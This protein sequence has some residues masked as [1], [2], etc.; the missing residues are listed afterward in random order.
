MEKSPTRRIFRTLQKLNKIEFKDF[1]KFVCSPY[2]NSNKNLI[3]YYNFLERY[4]PKFKEVKTTHERIYKALFPGKKFNYGILRNLN[5]EMVTVFKEFLAYNNYRKKNIQLNCNLLEEL[6]KRKLESLFN[7]EFK[8]TFEK[9]DSMQTRDED[10]YLNKFLLES[11]LN[12]YF[13]EKL[14]IGK[15][16][17]FYKGKTNEINDLTNYFII[18]ILEA[19]ITQISGGGKVDFEESLI[20]YDEIMSYISSN[21]DYYKQIDII[22]LLYNFLILLKEP[23]NEDVYNNLKIILKEKRHTIKDYD[24]KTFYIELYNYC[25]R[26]Q[27]EGSKK[28]GL[29]SF[30]MLKNMLE[31]GVF[32]V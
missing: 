28:Y 18:A 6:R 26:K 23:D 3:K 31:T 19:Y 29:E 7:K 4:H 14:T 8:T 24:I 17:S 30:E 32:F 21:L 1:G 25:K 20:L 11:E 27:A 2:H 16:L 22:F 10:Y 9:I 12:K 15:A 5:S 13:D